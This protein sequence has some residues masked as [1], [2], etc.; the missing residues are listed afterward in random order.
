MKGNSTRST[1]LKS[2]FHLCATLACICSLRARCLLSSCYALRIY[3]A[4]RPLTRPLHNY[5]N[6]LTNAQPQFYCI[7][8]HLA[9]VLGSWYQL[10]LLLSSDGLDFSE[11]ICNVYEISI[12]RLSDVSNYFWLPL[13]AFKHSSI[14]ASKYIRS[15][16]FILLQD[17]RPSWGAW[18]CVHRTLNQQESRSLGSQKGL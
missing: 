5:K 8:M 16:E 11:K 12:F 7:E 2:G 18:I 3:H 1:E 4:M 15:S 9:I 10:N 13:R 6:N 17:C 14:Q